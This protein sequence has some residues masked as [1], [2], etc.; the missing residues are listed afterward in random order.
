MREMDARGIASAVKD[1]S[2]RCADVRDGDY[3]RDGLLYCGVCNTR[4]QTYVTIGGKTY[5]VS[6]TCMHQDSDWIAKNGS[7]PKGIPTKAPRRSFAD[8]DGKNPYMIDVKDFAEMFNPKSQ[9]GL[10]LFGSSGTGKTFACEC[11][12]NY[13]VKAGHSVVMRNVPELVQKA[14]ID[15]KWIDEAVACRLLILDDLGAERGS[16]YAREIVYTAVNSRYARSKPIV[17]TTNLSLAEMENARDVSLQRVFGRILEWA[18]PLDF[19]N[20]NRRLEIVK[21]LRM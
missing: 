11:L 6:C 12:M 4:K 5:K 16:E 9:T 20:V 17:V 18:V 10:L 13:L 2:D 8:D 7:R 14:D 21:D 19:G 3:M 1:M 15:G